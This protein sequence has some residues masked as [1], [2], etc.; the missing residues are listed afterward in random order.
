MPDRFA[1]S[2]R[3]MEDDSLCRK[4]SILCGTDVFLCRD[5]RQRISHNV[6]KVNEPFRYKISPYFDRRIKVFCILQMV[7]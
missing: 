3:E 2:T 5:K 7:S 6:K 4:I 1:L